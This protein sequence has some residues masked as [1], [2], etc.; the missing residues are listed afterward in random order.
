MDLP[1]HRSFV[2]DNSLHRGID[3]CSLP[4][5]LWS[6]VFEITTTI[7]NAMNIYVQ[8]QAHTADS[9][10]IEK[11]V[12][13]ISLSPIRGRLAQQHQPQRLHSPNMITPR[14]QCIVRSSCIM[15]PREILASPQQPLLLYTVTYTRDDCCIIT[16]EAGRDNWLPRSGQPSRKASH[17]GLLVHPLSR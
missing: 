9:F 13:I 7:A 3:S 17:R 4:P 11:S 5:H 8:L 1:H 10:V 16:G 12:L 2:A 14:S 6:H 15:T